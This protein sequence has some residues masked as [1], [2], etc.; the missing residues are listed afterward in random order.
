MNST[1]NA[2][3]S[4]TY[5][6]AWANVCTQMWQP[7]ACGTHKL[8]TPP[9]AEKGERQSICLLFLLHAI[10]MHKMLANI[11]SWWIFFLRQTSQISFDFLNAAL[12]GGL[13]RTKIYKLSE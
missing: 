12:R 8:S 6:E 7:F 3:G 9:P 1:P 4:R 5:G 10:T 2:D 13:T 11:D